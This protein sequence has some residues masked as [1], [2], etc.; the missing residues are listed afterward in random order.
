LLNSGEQTCDK[1]AFRTSLWQRETEK[2][3]GKHLNVQR[4]Q[5]FP[6]T[7]RHDDDDN[8]NTIHS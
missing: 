6:R 1:Q 4:P 5:M 3:S 2:Y 7:G 8:D